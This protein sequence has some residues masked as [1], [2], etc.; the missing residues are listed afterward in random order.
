MKKNSSKIL[1]GHCKHKRI[2]QYTWNQDTQDIKYKIDYI[3]ARQNS[4]LKFQNIRE[5]KGM[6][7]GGNHYLVNAKILFLCRKTN[8]N[9][10]REN[11]PDCAVEL[12][13]SPIYNEDSLRDECNNF[14]CKKR[15][16]EKLGEGTFESINECYEHLV[17]C[18]HQASEEALGETI[19]EVKLS[20]FI[21]GMKKL[22][23]AKREK[24]LKFV[25]SKDPQARIELGMM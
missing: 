20:L 24:Y 5:F 19:C 15:L 2:H 9:E 17:K 14:L 1:N 21:T 3:I 11:I 10:S 25:S 18:I 13:Q 12:L 4:G 7:V 16:D 23:K 6:I 22:I 8:A